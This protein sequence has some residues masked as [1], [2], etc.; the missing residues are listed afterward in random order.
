[1]STGKLSRKCITETRTQGSVCF[2]RDLN[3]DEDVRRWFLCILGLM[4]VSLCVISLKWYILLCHMGVSYQTSEGLHN[5]VIPGAC[6]A[7]VLSF[8]GASSAK[9]L[10][11]ESAH[12]TS[13]S[14]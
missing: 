3:L 4:G 2:P 7:S 10:L 13:C 8:V 6:S 12:R 14:M 9:R 11:W 5:R 1:M